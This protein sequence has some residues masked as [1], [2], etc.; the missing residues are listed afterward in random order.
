MTP[1]EINA[2]RS[3][4]QRP[5]GISYADYSR[6]CFQAG[7]ADSIS[8]SDWDALP[9]MKG[10]AEPDDEMDLQ[11]M[12]FR[13]KGMTYKGYLE[14]CKSGGYQP[15]T[16]A[17]FEELD[18][19]EEDVVEKAEE[20]DIEE[21][22]E[23]DEDDVEEAGDDDDVDEDVDDEEDAEGEAEKSLRTSDLL[24]A[25][26][27][28]EDTEDALTAPRN[29]SREDYLHARLDA[30]TI[31]KSERTE[32]GRIWAGELEEEPAD[33]QKS[34]IDTLHEDDNS[35]HLV[36][37]SDFLRTLVKG[38][39][40]R[41]GDVLG[42]ITRDGHATRELMKAQGSLIKSL[43]AHAAKQDRV[44]KA[45]AQ[46]LETVEQAPAPRRAVR[47]RRDRV[48]DRSMQKSVYGGTA[49]DALSKSDVTNGLRALLMHAV[50][51]NDTTAVQRI[52]QA[53]ALFEQTGSIP[54][55]IMDAVRQ[56]S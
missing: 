14:A 27:A 53:T 5:H 23:E 19:E 11:K 15:M 30:G 42:S 13:P 6:M 7:V 48:A 10:A 9:L 12:P 39:D 47:A 38:V 25:I 34:L 21:D 51:K 33:L 31:S 50:D 52:T 44:I 37:A 24:K 8:K 17:D 4:E 3:P 28:Y 56:V 41:M 20:D 1:A 46:R 29:Q 43:A 55:H 54:S 32:L 40:D 45:M 35:A 36:D 18:E 22:M 49:Q 16:K 2:L 26:A